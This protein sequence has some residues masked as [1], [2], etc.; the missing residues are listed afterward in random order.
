M[1]G[2][3]ESWTGEINELGNSTLTSTC[4]LRPLPPLTQHVGLHAEDGG[5][6]PQCKE[7]VVRIL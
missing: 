6:P 7:A 3:N 1:L 5:C 4:L 2:F